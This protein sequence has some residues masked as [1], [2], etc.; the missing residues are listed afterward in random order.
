MAH[1]FEVGSQA[2]S[3]AAASSIGVSVAGQSAAT[4]A[5]HVYPTGAS[6]GSGSSEYDSLAKYSKES[7]KK[8]SNP[9]PGKKKRMEHVRVVN[10]PKGHRVKLVGANL[11]ELA[12]IFVKWAD[13]L[14][15]DLRVVN[16]Q[17]EA[18][19]QFYGK[20]MVAG[21]IGANA[22]CLFLTGSMNSEIINNGTKWRVGM[23]ELLA[24]KAPPKLDSAEFPSFANIQDEKKVFIG[25]V[26][27]KMIYTMLY[28]PM[29][30]MLKN[31]NGNMK[32]TE[33]QTPNEAPPKP[34]QYVDNPRALE[35]FIDHVMAKYERIARDNAAE[36]RGDLTERSFREYCGDSQRKRERSLQDVL[37]RTNR[38]I[39]EIEERMLKKARELRDAQKEMAMVRSGALDKELS[40]QARKMNKL[41]EDGLFV[42]FKVRHGFLVGLTSEIVIEHEEKKHPLGRFMISI[43]KD[44]KVKMESENRP[45]P[46][47]PHL[48]AEGGFCLGNIGQD[49]PKLI[50]M[51]RYAM[52]FTILHEFLSSYN[53]S[54]RVTDLKICSGAKLE[55][56]MEVDSVPEA[57]PQGVV[58]PGARPIPSPG[59]MPPPPLGGDISRPITRSQEAAIADINR[60][61][62]E[63][64]ARAI[65]IPRDAPEP[66][67]Q[68]VGRMQM[69]AERPTGEVWVSEK[70]DQSK[71]V[72]ELKNKRV[73]EWEKSQGEIKG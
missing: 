28:V 52:A 62:N 70:M 5:G 7:M 46:A 47:H 36:L 22:L 55:P 54:D 23:D 2:A 40:D 14:D 65:G 32:A 61:V 35:P 1:G 18:A 6:A 33:P 42:K 13:R 59:M 64:L 9:V 10:S 69:Y 72:Y 39:K 25:R 41:V 48:R 26:D 20:P 38:E 24:L 45:H 15:K 43:D 53:P 11:G 30:E 44:G 19:Y 16:T 29:A 73:V 51:E 71:T 63:D 21:R 8:A 31:L 57:A 68:T 34:E 12:P 49:V 17:G 58:P 3:T 50:G 56:T 67:K 37:D 60:A 66:S 27:G 4:S